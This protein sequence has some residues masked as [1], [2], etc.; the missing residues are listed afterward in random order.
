MTIIVEIE[1]DLDEE[2]DI[3]LEYPDSENPNAISEAER[4]RM[5]R[6]DDVDQLHSH[7]LQ[8]HPRLMDERI[9]NEMLTGIQC[10]ISIF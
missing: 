3:I 5:W 8:F 10:S 7:V 9:M 1:A 4:N 2:I 6:A